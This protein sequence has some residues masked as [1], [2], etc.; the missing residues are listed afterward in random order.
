MSW[1]FSCCVRY[2]LCPSECFINKSILYQLI[3]GHDILINIKEL[4]IK[5]MVVKKDLEVQ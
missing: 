3:S 4:E 5:T 1:V 2:F